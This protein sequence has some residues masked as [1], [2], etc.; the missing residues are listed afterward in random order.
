MYQFIIH[1]ASK[2]LNKLKV[3]GYLKRTKNYEV[4][5]GLKDN[6]LAIY[7]LCRVWVQISGLPKT[8]SG[9]SLF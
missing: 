9:A 3:V 4:F 2:K 8:R 1:L 5:Y 6:E 7:A